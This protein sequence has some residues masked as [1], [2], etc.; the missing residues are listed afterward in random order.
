MSGRKWREGGGWLFL[1]YLW[2]INWAEPEKASFRICTSSDDRSVLAGSLE[3]NHHFFLWFTGIHR[4]TWNTLLRK[5][6]LFIIHQSF[7]LF[8]TFWLPTLSADGG[9]HCQPAKHTKTEPF[10]CRCPI[11]VMH[12]YVFPSNHFFL[13]C[14]SLCRRQSGASSAYNGVPWAEQNWEKKN[15]NWNIPASKS[16]KATVARVLTFQKI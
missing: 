9:T 6:P 2:N 14:S 15:W 7:N 12:A 3:K 5:L 16:Q 8:N 4:F 13:P 1:H 11:W 10:F